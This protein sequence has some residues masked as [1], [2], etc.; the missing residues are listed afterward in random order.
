MVDGPTSVS[1]PAQNFLTG[2]IQLIRKPSDWNR[3]KE[4]IT[5][6]GKLPENV[7]PGTR[8]RLYYLDKT[9]RLVKAWER[10]Y[11]H[12]NVPIGTLPVLGHLDVNDIQGSTSL[13][14]LWDQQL[15]GG[16]STFYKKVDVQVG[17]PISMDG[18]AT[19]VSS[20][21][22]DVE[23]QFPGNTFSSNTFVT[24]RVTNPLETQLNQNSQMSVVGPVVEI[25]PS[26]DFSS[27]PPDQRPIVKMKLTRQDLKVP[28]GTG[29]F[30]DMDPSS[31]KLYKPD[32]VTG[33]LK[34]LS[35][36]TYMFFDATGS[37][38]CASTSS[39]GVC[40]D[41]WDY[42]T[43][44]GNTESFS[45]FVALNS[46]NTITTDYDLIVNP[47]ESTSLERQIEIAGLNIGDFRMFLDDDEVFF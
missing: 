37:T 17:A 23:V 42:M 36:L 15:G 11:K 25:L 6:R 29:G 28:N 33:S 1:Y 3:A 46:D 20:I 14:L 44:A 31:I 9:G 32:L 10:Y 43:I 39:T 2:D 7:N 4:L 13:F 45:I 24:V 16:L 27:L 34:E 18:S 12:Q 40:I 21:Y 19:V 30:V 22:G 38:L 5:L 8:Y 47:E 41:N 35:N 26:Y